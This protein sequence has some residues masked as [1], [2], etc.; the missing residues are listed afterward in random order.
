MYALPAS[1]YYRHLVV[2][3]QLS[4]ERLQHLTVFAPPSQVRFT[5]SRLTSTEA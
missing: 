3:P 4:N 1:P 5:A 2:T